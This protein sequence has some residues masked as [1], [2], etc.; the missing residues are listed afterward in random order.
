LIGDGWEKLGFT[1]YAPVQTHTGTRI[2][3]FSIT[4]SL[5]VRI[6][7]PPVKNQIISNIGNAH[8]Q[9]NNTSNF[10]GKLF[11]LNDGDQEPQN[12][13]YLSNPI[14]MQ[15]IEIEILNCDFAP[16]YTANFGAG[17]DNNNSECIFVFA[18]K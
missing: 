4:P 11:Y 1:S 8:F 17:R 3:D 5:I 12:T 18:V 13:I 14:M 10:G 2:T 15:D 16:L 6:L 7:N 9:L